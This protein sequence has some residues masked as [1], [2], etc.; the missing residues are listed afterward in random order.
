MIWVHSDAM[1]GDGLTKQRAANKLH[2]FFV[3]G[4]T[5]RLVHDPMFKSARRRKCIGMG[6]LEDNEEKEAADPAA[7]RLPREGPPAEIG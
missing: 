6:A 5:W 1:L 4:Q 3:D 7:S 2:Q